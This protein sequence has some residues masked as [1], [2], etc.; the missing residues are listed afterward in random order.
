LYSFVFWFLLV[1]LDI[2]DLQF[3]NPYAD[4]SKTSNRL[5]HWEQSGAVYFVTFRLAD[6]VPKV[7]LDQWS[8]EREVWLAH[9]PQPW[10]SGVEQE[11]HRR[12]SSA[13]ERW[14]DAGHGSCVLRQAVCREV[15]AEA[16]QFF[17]GQRSSQLAWVV[18]PNH[19]H[20]LFVLNA[21]WPLEGLLHSWKLHSALK[22]NQL[23]GKTGTLWQKDYFDRL[24]RD[25]DHFANC[26]RYI[27]RNPFKSHLKSGEYTQYESDLAKSIP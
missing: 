23:L 22:I 21:E 5:P 1:A 7:L 2:T 14:L 15:I 19:V 17:E 26:V 16:L 18:M 12:F 20:A 3:F 4:T 10:T 6:A 11:Y 27:R 24:V 25:G 8:T 9:H 13:T